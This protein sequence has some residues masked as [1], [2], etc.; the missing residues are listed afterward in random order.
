M[1]IQVN[2]KKEVKVFVN[3]LKVIILHQLGPFFN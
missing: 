1:G 2:L 3:V